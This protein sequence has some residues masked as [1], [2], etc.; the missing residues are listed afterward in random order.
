MQLTF[1]IV[2]FKLL[3]IKFENI[4]AYLHFYLKKFLNLVNFNLL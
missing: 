3:E 2:L 1:N 4:I